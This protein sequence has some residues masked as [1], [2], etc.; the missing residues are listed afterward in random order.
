MYTEFVIIIK[1]LSLFVKIAFYFYIYFVQSC[2]T[3]AGLE[4]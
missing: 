1:W 2:M 3:Y 4:W